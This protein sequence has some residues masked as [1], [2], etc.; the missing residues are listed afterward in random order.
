[1]DGRWKIAVT[2]TYADDE[3]LAEIFAAAESL[4]DVNFYITGNPQKLPRRVLRRKPENCRLTGYLSYEQYVGLLRSADAVMDLTTRNHTLLM[5]GFESVSLGKPLITS[6]WPILKEYFSS[7]AVYVDNSADGIAAG[8]RSILTDLP[9]FQRDIL[10]LGIE[11]Q[12][13]WESRIREIRALFPNLPSG[14]R[15]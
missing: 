3:P 14:K 7:G 5:G 10:R 6:D 2:C 12:S 8:V 11:L 1:M 4:R 15:S 9:F 13:E